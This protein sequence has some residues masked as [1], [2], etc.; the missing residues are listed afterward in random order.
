MKSFRIAAHV[1]LASLATLCS[2]IYM[3][4][5]GTVSVLALLCA[6]VINL[7]V[8]TYFIC[9]VADIADCL[10]LCCIIETYM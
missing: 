3:N 1:F 6:F 4:S 9:L 5:R 10:M 7:F 8:A 2:F